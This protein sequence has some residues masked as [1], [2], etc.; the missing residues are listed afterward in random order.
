MQPRDVVRLGPE[1]FRS[2]VSCLGQ[3]LVELLHVIRGFWPDLNWYIADVQ[4]INALPLP[5]RDPIPMLVGDTDKLIHIAQRVDQF[6]SGVFVGIRSDADRPAFR[7]GGLWTEDEETADLGDAVLEIRAFD[8]S[9]WSIATSD[10]N[11]ATTVRRRL[12]EMGTVPGEKRSAA[13]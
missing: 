5:P 8:T 6:E 3:Q 1:V 4:A 2:N 13:E 11:L 9:Y 12:S 7:P 10:A